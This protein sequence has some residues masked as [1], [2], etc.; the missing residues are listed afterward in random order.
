MYVSMNG[1]YLVSGVGRALVFGWYY[2]A[3]KEAMAILGPNVLDNIICCNCAKTV[4]GLWDLVVVNLV[5]S[6]L[7]VLNK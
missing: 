6:M 3:D 4:K 1:V 7:G 2:E 5:P